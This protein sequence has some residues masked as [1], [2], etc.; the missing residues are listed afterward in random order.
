MS[1]PGQNLARSVPSK[2]ATVVAYDFA[3]G[4][5]HDQSGNGYDARV[6]G[7]GATL[8]GKGL[9]LRAGSVVETPLGSLG[10]DHTFQMTLSLS[11]G[12]VLTLSGPDTTL[13]LQNGEAPTI[14]ASNGFTYPLRDLATNASLPLDFTDEAPVTFATTETTGTEAWIAGRK[15]GN[16]NTPLSH[17]MNETYYASV[18]YFADAR[19]GG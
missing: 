11:A 1:A 5:L 10:I 6:V 8:T 13:T 19:S 2:S 4:G 18:P 16:F 12:A 3:A 14:T 17:F 9:V 15:I 7:R